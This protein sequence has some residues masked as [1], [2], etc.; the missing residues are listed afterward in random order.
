MRTRTPEPGVIYRSPKNVKSEKSGAWPLVNLYRFPM[1]STL[2]SDATRTIFFPRTAL[3]VGVNTRAAAASFALN[4]DSSRSMSSLIIVLCRMLS[5]LVIYS[6]VS[7]NGFEVI[8]G[9][10]G[11]YGLELEPDGYNREV[12]RSVRRCGF[13]VGGLYGAGFGRSGGRCGKLMVAV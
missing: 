2:P 3:A 9:R 13:W 6:V 12:I 10:M 5:G 4:H 7:A 11:E 8:L 1:S